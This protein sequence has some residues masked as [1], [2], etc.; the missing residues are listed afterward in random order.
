MTLSCRQTI[1][2]P[3]VIQGTMTKSCRQTIQL[4]KKKRYYHVTERPK[5][6]GNVQP[7][8]QHSTNTKSCSTGPA[9]WKIYRKSAVLQ[10][11]SPWRTGEKWPKYRSIFFALGLGVVLYL[12]L[13]QPL[14]VDSGF[15]CTFEFRIGSGRGKSEFGV[16]QGCSATRTCRHL[17]LSPK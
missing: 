7:L 16:R 14:G 3:I 5:W 12:P 6:Q 4:K 15:C 11:K 10:G 17:P 1:I 13:M 2:Q 9:L 8:M